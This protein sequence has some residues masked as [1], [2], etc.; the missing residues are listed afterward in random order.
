MKETKDD[1]LK[2]A[3]TI[4]DMIESISKIS[5]PIKRE[6]YVR[7]CAK[8]MEISEEV[9]FASLAQMNQQQVLKAQQELKKAQKETPMA[10]VKTPDRIPPIV[11]L[12]KDLI[13][14]LILY[15]AKECTFEDKYLY[16]DPETGEEKTQEVSQR[17]KVF[18]KL[19]LELQADE[20]ELSTLEFKEIYTFFIDKYQ[21]GLEDISLIINELPVSMAAIIAS[22]QAQEEQIRLH[23]WSKKGVEVKPKEEDL[24]YAINGII[25]NLRKLLIDKKIEE[26]RQEITTLEDEGEDSSWAFQ[27]VMDYNVLKSTISR[28]LGAT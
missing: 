14:Y 23:N 24:P 18:E 13:K 12:E 2:R 27:E 28:R 6:I 3:D 4:R 21:A 5:D 26:L 17:V 16:Y 22:F 25:L 19:F 1:P 8:I 11:Y 10:A 9:L 15:G 20:I 7:E